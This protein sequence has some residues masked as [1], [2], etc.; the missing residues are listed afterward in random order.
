[1]KGGKTMNTK[2][3]KIEMIRHDDTLESLAKYLGISIPTMHRKMTGE[4]NF[5][6]DEMA[7][8]KERYNLSTDRF[9]EIFYGE[10]V[11]V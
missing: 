5:K 9:V 10:G 1:M 7:K 8:I 11:K 3:L 2:E 4:T 6:Q